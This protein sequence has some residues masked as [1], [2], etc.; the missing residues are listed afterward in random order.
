M[1]WGII[2]AMDEEVAEL[3]K[4]M[5]IEVT[6]QIAHVMFYKGTLNGRDIVLC[7]SGVGKVNGALTA[8]LLIDHFQVNVIVFTGVAGALDP[9][10]NIEDIVISSSCQQHDLDATAL[11]FSRGEVPMFS[12]ESVFKA[13]EMLI[14]QALAAGKHLSDVEVYTGKI[15]SGDQFI[16]DKKEVE[17]LFL[18]FGGKCVEMEGAAVAHAAVVNEVPFLIIRSMSDKADGEATINFAEFTKRASAR[19]VSIIKGML[20]ER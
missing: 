6:Q 11:G 2:G 18:T 10:L 20:S 3:R 8:Q 7:K 5:N 15:L 13:D 17:D 19:A 14:N 1:N 12:R 9:K 16:A 4:E